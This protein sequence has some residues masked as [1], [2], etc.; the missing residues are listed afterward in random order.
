MELTIEQVL[1]DNELLEK[2]LNTY[3][4]IKRT[5][6]R[7]YEKNKEKMINKSKEQYAKN[8]EANPKEPKIKKTEDKKA[9]MKEYMI[10]YKEKKLNKM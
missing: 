10:K 4:S 7:Y 9:Y 6:K 5:E 3:N 2:V 1:N 8:K